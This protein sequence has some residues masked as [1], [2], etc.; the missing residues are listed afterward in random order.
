MIRVFP[1]AATQGFSDKN[2]PGTSYYSQN[3]IPSLYGAATQY[4]ILNKR[5]SVQVSGMGNIKY[6]ANANGVMYAQDDAGQILKE[7]TPGAYDFTIARSPGGNGAGL[8]GDQFGNLLYAQNTT[9]GLY[10]GTTWTDNLQN[11]I[12]GQHPMDT[13]EDLRVIA[14]VSSVAVL[15][16]DGT[17]NPT[18]FSIP[19]KMSIAA[20]RSGP[21][22]ILIGAN[23]GYQG[24]LILWDGNATRSK[25]TW[26]WTKGKIIAIDKFG[27]NWIVKTQRETLVTNGYTIKPLFSILNDPLSFNA[28]ETSLTP[29]QLLV[30]NDDLIFP[31]TSRSSGPLNYEFGKIKPG[32]YLYSLSRHAWSYLPLPTGNSINVDINAVF[33][34]VNN[35][36]IFLSYR[37][38]KLTNNYI[39]AITN[40][41]PTSALWIS[42]E[43]G[44]GRPHYQ[45]TFFGPTDKVAEAVII[46]LGLLNSITDPATTTFNIAL[47]LY[48]FKR[49]LWG[50]QVTTAQLGANNQI[51]V[52]GTNTAYSTA[53]VGDEVTILNGLNAGSVAHITSIANGGTNTETWTLDT[54]FA[55]PTENN[56]YLN[57]QPFVLVQKKVFTSLSSLKNIYFDVRNDIKAKQFL[58][59]VVIDNIGANLALEL[60]TSYFVFDDIG[61][62]QT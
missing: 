20:L 32:V 21:T 28:Y 18:A 31:I 17:W 41:P 14:N 13:F 10:D 8:L 27:E 40:T 34:D 22:G 6:F 46:N 15:F 25:T 4:S 38:N 48:D 61:Y 43:I 51:R 9:L 5:T 59:K 37:D 49:Q 55:N 12:A 29:Q 24:A 7:Q 52:D 19:S 36:R 57:V 1:F 54:T 30:I 56:V 45:R 60:Q 50:A 58:A 11:L 53:R 42:E 3:F 62:D 16:S 39:A 2:I 47:K 33:P 23:F 26:K 44:I 35:N